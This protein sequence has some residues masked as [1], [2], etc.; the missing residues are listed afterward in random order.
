MA[1]ANILLL[2]GCTS[3]GK[4]S[5]TR[6]LHAQLPDCWLRFGIDDAFGM[7]P[8]TLHDNRNGFWFDTDAWGD[9]RL[10]MGPAGQTTLAAYRRAV[11][12]MANAGARVIVDEVI[13]DRDARDDWLAVL[14]A[15]GVIMCGVRCGLEELCR[16]ERARGDR[17]VGQARGQ[18]RHVHDGMIYDIE[19]DTTSASPEICAQQISVFLAKGATAHALAAMRRADQN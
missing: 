2:N 18:F 11:V 7:L 13:L 19:V 16:R 17:L 15:D 5:L 1:K 14:P 9:P 10:N 4:S 8:E 12:A 6:A 3:A